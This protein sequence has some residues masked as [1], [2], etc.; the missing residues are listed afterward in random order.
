MTPKQDYVKKME[1][2]K[3]RRV[4]AGI[5]SDRYP[6]VSN[7]V[8]HM[9][10]FHEAENPVLMERTINVFPTSIADFKM[11]CMIRGCDSGG[12]D[13]TPV[14]SKL[15]KQHKKMAKGDMNCRGKI[16]DYSSH[17]ANVSYEISIKYNNKHSI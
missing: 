14:I 11:E 4:E 8:I 9:T 1:L 17:H 7:I 2:K 13:L 6:G 10:Y 15:I 16:G 5:V 12:F 3:L